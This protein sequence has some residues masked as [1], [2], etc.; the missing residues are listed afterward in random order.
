MCVAHG[1]RCPL[2]PPGSA[3]FER[4]LPPSAWVQ[5]PPPPDARV[6]RARSSAPPSVLPRSM[7]ER[8]DVKT[9]HRACIVAFKKRGYKAFLVLGPFNICI[10][11]ARVAT[12]HPRHNYTSTS[13]SSEQLYRW[14]TRL[15]IQLNAP[16][17]RCLARQCFRPGDLRALGPATRPPIES[18]L[19]H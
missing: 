13:R 19:R 10:C 2:H 17:S 15:R 16:P 9:R 4:R 5:R 18:C 12:L 11:G 3:A 6:T 14:G 7:D 8:L 1:R